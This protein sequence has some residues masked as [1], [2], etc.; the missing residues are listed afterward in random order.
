ML[1]D[2]VKAVLERALEEELSAH[3]GYDRHDPAGHNSGN[4]R[5]GSI[6]KTV[7]TGIGPVRLSV[8]RDRTGTFEPVLVPKGPAVFPA[9]WTT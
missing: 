7:Q 8:P 3:L 5:N 1:G 2:L 4:S 9:A 6:G